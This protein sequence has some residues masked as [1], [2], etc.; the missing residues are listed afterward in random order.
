LESLSALIVPLTL[1]AFAVGALVV[2]TPHVV[3]SRAAQ[4]IE[5]PCTVCQHALKAA[6]RDLR[7]VDAQ[8]SGFVVRERPGVYGRPL[9]ELRC[10][11]CGAAHVYAVD[12]SPPEYVMTNAVSATARLNTCSQCRVPLRKPAWPRGTFDGKVAEA[13][14]LDAKHGLVCGRCSAV[15]CIECC[16]EASRGRTAENTLRCPRCFRVPIERF[17]HF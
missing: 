7:K 16:R 12:R 17:H 14:G 3:R 5:T 1:A 15:V 13:P 9:G 2:L 6:V 8:E 11:S 10:P 4:G